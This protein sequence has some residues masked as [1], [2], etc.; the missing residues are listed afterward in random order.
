M[1]WHGMARA[2][3]VVR[4]R[5]EGRTSHWMH[6]ACMGDRVLTHL[7]SHFG[8]SGGRA[9]S[10][11]ITPRFQITSVGKETRDASVRCGERSKEARHSSAQCSAVQCSAVQCSTYS[12]CIHRPQCQ[13]SHNT[14]QRWH[15]T[16]QRGLSFGRERAQGQEGQAG[17][18][19]GGEGHTKQG[20]HTHTHRERAKA[21]GKTGERTYVAFLP[22]HV[23]LGHHVAA[24]VL[25]N[26]SMAMSL[27]RRVIG[28]VC[29][30]HGL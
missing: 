6:H 9:H 20:K 23:P 27:K 29:C 10:L 7:V 16:A 5:S 19:R 17:R 4:S 28:L 26:A 21:G 15:G 25:Y 12:H 22:L 14:T 18:Q 13:T 11:Q 8:H 2:A 30:S 24:I 1:A 3:D